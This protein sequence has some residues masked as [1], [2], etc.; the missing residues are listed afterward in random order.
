MSKILFALVNKET[1]NIA[2]QLIKEMNLDIQIKV[3]YLLKE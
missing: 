3:I 2:S 1:A